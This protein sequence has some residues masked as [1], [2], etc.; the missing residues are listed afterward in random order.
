MAKRKREGEEDIPN[1]ADTKRYDSL[2][3]K[4]SERNYVNLVKEK[5]CRAN[6]A[7]RGLLEVAMKEVR[8]IDVKKEDFSDSNINLKKFCNLMRYSAPE[9]V[10]S[11]GA[12][13]EGNNVQFIKR[14]MPHT[15]PEALVT[16]AKIAELFIMD[17]ALKAWHAKDIETDSAEKA[18]SPHEISVQD[19]YR[20]LATHDELDMLCLGTFIDQPTSDP[21]IVLLPNAPRGANDDYTTHPLETTTIVTSASAPRSSGKASSSKVSSG[22]SSKGKQPTVQKNKENALKEMAAASQPMGRLAA[23]GAF[24][25]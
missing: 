5:V 15:S 19:I 10:T 9:V 16:M 8:A 3:I 2:S 1:S 17:F 23:G 25:D 14:S 13:P 6:L 7:S 12:N 11:T 21:T 20:T 4:E 18:S 24:V 22:P